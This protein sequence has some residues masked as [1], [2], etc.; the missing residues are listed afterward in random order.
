MTTTLRT[1]LL[2]CAAAAALG[3]LV[4]PPRAAAQEKK[5][6]ILFS[7]KGGE[8]GAA[9]VL[10]PMALQQL[11]VY[12]R[13]NTAND[14]EVTVEV[15]A[16]GV[17]VEG[18]VQKVAVKHDETA[19][20]VFAMPAAPPAAPPAP[21]A[22]KPQPPALQE[23]EGA[24]QIVVLD[25]EGKQV[26]TPADLQ[27]SRP[28][29][30]VKVTEISYS[31]SP[32]DGGAKNMLT[33][34]LRRPK[35][36]KGFVGPLSRVDLILRPDRIPGLVDAPRKEGTQGGFLS[37]DGELTLTAEDLQ[38]EG[39]GDK[40]GLVYLA[41]DGWQR[42]FTYYA[43]F[44]PAGEDVTPQA[45]N[46]IPVL[47]LA[48]PVFANPGG[49]LPVGLEVD[50]AA[51]LEIR[52]GFDRGVHRDFKPDP[53]DVQKFRGDRRVR[54]LLAA[55]GPG[56]SLL[57]QP[58]VE[59]WKA[60]WDAAGVFGSRKVGVEVFDNNVVKIHNAEDATAAAA[61][62]EWA[63]VDRIEKTVTLD[64]APPLGIKL[65]F[66]E[67]LLR[68]A[69]LPVQA[70]STDKPSEIK[71]VFFY[72]G[73]PGPDGAPPP[74][75]VKVKGEW[76]DKEQVWAAML[77]A[78]PAPTD[79]KGRVD[80]T[81]TFV[82][83]TNVAASDTATV[84]LVD[85]AA[86]AGPKPGSI[87]GAVVEGGLGQPGLEV[88]LLDDKGAVKDAVKTNATGKYLFDGV[89]AGSYRVAAAKAT[90]STK[91]ETAAM[92]LDGKKLVGVDINLQR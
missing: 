4:L 30:Y 78:P 76:H 25:K 82:K 72:V 90:D 3:P 15:T 70:V 28:T 41:V 39:A 68:G 79:Q 87:E 40:H 10:H 17:P 73:R 35:V 83:L 65:A 29:D 85:P 63:K 38:F 88:R 51:G 52:A 89:A 55:G 50:N 57:I 80:V 62:D 37:N 36:D 45:I 1:P 60:E 64:A 59:D 84:Q 6:E 43:T 19:R 75:A 92:V 53:A 74:T 23:V 33:V 22:S 16:D 66:P 9:L 71:E 61:A 18:T 2:L 91:G 12:V 11:Y 31:P 27:L 44:P 86:A 47:R 24:L 49:P 5:F 58:A 81:V 48:A 7:D 67:K 13:N 77:P 8:P 32:K 42:A 20:V 34:R 26:A 56:G 54:M 21:P 69:D 14:D 46:N